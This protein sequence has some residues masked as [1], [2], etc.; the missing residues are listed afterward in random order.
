MSWASERET[1]RVEDKACCLMCLFNVNMPLFYGEGAKA[2]T[3]L[4]HEL[5]KDTTDDS[6]LA[7]LESDSRE[8]GLLT[9]SPTSFVASKDIVGVETRLLIYSIENLVRSLN[10]LYLSGFLVSH[11]ST[12][13][14]RIRRDRLEKNIKLLT[15]RLFACDQT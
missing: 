3:R 6:I 2:F 14:I 9:P 1:T 15:Q 8:T 12:S 13:L 10:R 7:W 11:W 4:Q 5:L